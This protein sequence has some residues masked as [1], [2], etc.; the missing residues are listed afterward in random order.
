MGDSMRITPDRMVAVLGAAPKPAK[1]WQEQFDYCQEVL[2][3]L[4][5][6][7]WDK[8]A[9]SYDYVAITQPW[10]PEQIDLTRLDKYYE[11]SGATVFRVR[12]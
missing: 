3:R 10:A 9:Q 5:Q 8:I 6:A 11:N 2:E 4:A 7:D 1:I 12:R